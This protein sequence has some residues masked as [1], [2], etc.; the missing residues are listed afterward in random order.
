MA[1][2]VV[3][4]LLFSVIALASVAFIKWITTVHGAVLCV[5]VCVCVCVCGWVGVGEFL[6]GEG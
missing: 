1:I 2:C 5:W 6:A 3:K 4:T